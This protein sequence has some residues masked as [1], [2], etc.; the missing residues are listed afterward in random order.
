MNTQKWTAKIDETTHAF[1]QAFGHLTNEQLNWKPHASVWSIAQNIDHLIVINATYF[2]IIESIRKG[3]YTLPWIARLGFMVTFFG[4]VVLDSVQP[5]RRRKMKTFPV[6]Q[7]SQSPLPGDVLA[8]FTE[9]QDKLKTL[10]TSSSDLVE[11]RTII[12]SPANKNIVYRL[13][14]A[15]DIITTHEQRHFEQAKEVLTLLN[16]QKP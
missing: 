7:P 12:S 9:A 8:R 11:L 4:N 10:V 13:E 15:F 2:P 6:W 1:Q 5:S 3:T 14:T 16:Q